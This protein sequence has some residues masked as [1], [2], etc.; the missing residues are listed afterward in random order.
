MIPS[1][2]PPTFTTPSKYS[3]ELNDFLAR[4]LAKK[5]EDR[6]TVEELLKHD[7]ITK[8]ARAANP[9]CLTDMITEASNRISQLGSRA[10]AVGFAPS[11]DELP[12]SQKSVSKKAGATL[13]RSQV[14]SRSIHSVCIRHNACRAGAH[15]F[16]VG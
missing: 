16:L 2:S 4:C 15:V 8:R 5:P 9:K 12:P 3:K 11:V 14:R 10:K 13:R 1:R 6:A 7:F